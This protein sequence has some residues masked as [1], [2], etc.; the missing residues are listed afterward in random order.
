MLVR[1]IFEEKKKMIEYVIVEDNNYL[2]KRIEDIILKVMKNQYLSFHIT[3]LQSKKEIQEQL[4]NTNFKVYI[5]DADTGLDIAKMIREV[6]Y[7]SMIIV[8]SSY[9]YEMELFANTYLMICNYI[10]LDENYEEKL[11]NEI[12]NIINRKWKKEIL[13]IG[14]P[15]MIYQ[16]P[17]KKILYITTDIVER[18]TIIVTDQKDFSVSIPLYQIKSQLDNN[19]VQV[20]RSYI[21]NT[22]KITCVDFR[23]KKIYFES[24]QN[25]IWMS[26]RYAQILKKNMTLDCQNK[27]KII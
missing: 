7:D 19:F 22:K 25:P 4:D 9:K 8:I 20:H 3:F 12:K 13:V 10:S 21:V 26:R 24:K 17:V 23:N 15:D 18:K 1:D 6:D 11:L 5:L 27:K 14:Y 2:K 16:I